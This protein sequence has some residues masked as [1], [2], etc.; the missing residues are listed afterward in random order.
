M[1]KFL[2]RPF[3]LNTPVNVASTVMSMAVAIYLAVTVPSIATAAT[4]DPASPTPAPRDQ[5]DGWLDLHETDL[6]VTAGS[7]LDFS[8]A[9]ANHADRSHCASWSFDA[10][11]PPSKAQLPDAIAQLK[12]S[13]FNYVRFIGIDFALMPPGASKKDFDWP[14]ERL[15]RLHAYLAALSQAG[16]AYQLNILSNDNGMYGGANWETPS[17]HVKAR[18]YTESKAQ[19][20]WKTMVDRVFAV[21]NPYTGKSILQD[22]QLKVVELVNEGNIAF[23]SDQDG[24]KFPTHFKAPF[25]QWLREQYADVKAWRA[26]WQGA[27]TDGEDPWSSNVALPSFAPR[28]PD[29]RDRDFSRY[30]VDAENAMVGWMGGYLRQRGYA[31]AV[32]AFNTYD[33]ME[34]NVVRGKL[35]YIDMHDYHDHPVGWG[36][37][38]TNAHTSLIGTGMKMMTGP[39]STRYLDRPFGMSEYG[40]VYFSRTRYEGAA[41]MGAYAAFQGWNAICQ[42]SHTVASLQYESNSD[43]TNRKTMV[44]FVIWSDPINAAGDRLNAFLFRRGDVAEAR[45]TVAIVMRPDVVRNYEIPYWGGWSENLRR[46]GLFH[47]LGM[48]PEST[49]DASGR[50]NGQGP[51]PDLV[52]DPLRQKE[53]ANPSPRVAF[54]PQ[55]WTQGS[56]QERVARLREQGLI[57][58]SNVTDAARGVIE[59]DTHQIRLDMPARAASIVTARSEVQIFD[60]QP[61]AA[62][63]DQR[64]TISTATPG[65]LVAAIALDESPL[66]QSRHILMMH[67]S[68]AL[69]T[70]I[71]FDGSDRKTLKQWGRWPVRIR[72]SKI[73][74]RMAL[75]DGRWNLYALNLKGD[76]VGRRPLDAVSS[77]SESKTGRATIL[78]TFKLDNTASNEP[79]LYYELVRDEPAAR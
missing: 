77:A 5:G 69:P 36:P 71:Q 79:A 49:V 18:V 55:G 2:P 12:R 6:R 56:W 40:H 78:Q 54:L 38:M 34:G 50:Y 15:D 17:L 16:I 47:K 59:T 7:A 75:A 27:T 52:L 48:I 73:D 14:A 68:D 10:S 61:L 62:R 33:S 70:D 53:D 29:R 63:T 43:W 76:R 8:A 64:M 3:V 25:N 21:P 51:A 41:L 45:K 46:I 74:V 20:H 26:E 44:P 39:F 24:R 37:G 66:A 1:T 28:T 42:F 32:T 57:D 58:A 23:V 67:L 22:P 31:G 60:Q 30:M 11:E 65:A 72:S 35:G 9:L 19:D 4:N 13:G